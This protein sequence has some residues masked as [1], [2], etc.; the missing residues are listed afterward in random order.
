MKKTLFPL[1]CVA[2]ALASCNK[3]SYRHNIY[4][5]YPAANISEFYADQT[6]DS[7]V[8][9]TF[10]SYKASASADWVTIDPDMASGDIPNAYY[11]MVEVSIP[12]TFEPNT[13]GKT[14]EC[15]VDIYNYG[16]NDW[17]ETVSAVFRQLGWL[18]ITNAT[19]TYGEYTDTA[20]S[21]SYPQTATFELSD[22]ATQV[23]DT[24]E[25]TV[26]GD[27]TLGHEADFF[28]IETTSGNAGHNVV[29]I[30][31]QTNGEE[32]ERSAD[33]VLTSRGVATTVR[34]TQSG[35]NR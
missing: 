18:N 34:L 32:G 28:S 27:W 1:L 4:I 17:A 29:P 24:L 3:E 25:F 22:S 20:S 26:Y 14:R 15:R 11:Y 35:T 30:V 9:A 6:Q 13:E 33:I 5:T 31:L 12:L 21:Y 10:D 16:E 8:F 7:I 23:A 2:V 19:I